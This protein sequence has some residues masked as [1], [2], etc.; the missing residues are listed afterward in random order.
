MRDQ[1]RDL[2]A[3]AGVDLAIYEETEI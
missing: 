2:C 3:Q 1:L